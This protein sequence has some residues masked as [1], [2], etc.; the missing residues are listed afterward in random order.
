MSLEI[1]QIH[2]VVGCLSS[3]YQGLE[4]TRRL[5][6]YYM[7]HQG[8]RSG[9]YLNWTECEGQMIGFKG[10]KYKLFRVLAEAEGFVSQA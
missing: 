8:R 9:V 2:G 4:I 1:V 7:V 5:S 6:R 3:K 10:A